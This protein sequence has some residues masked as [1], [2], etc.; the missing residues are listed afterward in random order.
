[1][2]VKNKI[3]YF[4]LSAF[5][6]LR[7]LSGKYISDGCIIMASSIAFYFLFFI[8]PLGLLLISLS[9]I[10]INR[11]EFQSTIL[12]F[13]EERIPIIYGFAE[14]NLSKIVENRTSI[15]I[16]GFIFLAIS[17][18]YIFDSIQLSLNKIYKTRTQ[19]KYWKQKIFGFLIITLILIIVII[20]FL[21]STS[22]FYL[23][24]RIVDYFKLND[25][26]SSPLFKSISIILGLAFNFAIFSLIYFFGTNKKTHFKYHIYKGALF[27]AIAWEL[28]KHIFIFYINKFVNFELTYGSIGSIIGFLLWIYISS[29]ILIMGAE[30]NSLDL[31]E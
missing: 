27:A 31:V 14:S 12:S 25:S 6:Y 5:K 16:T 23:A 26:I 10:L 20:S 28:S 22:F 8:F 1:M 30:I 21:L 11:F 13:V 2:R 15:G 9:G 17:T 29:L 3:K 18:T 24:N 7:K 19:R 4:I